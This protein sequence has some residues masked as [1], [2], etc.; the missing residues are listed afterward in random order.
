MKVAQLA[1]KETFFE[2]VREVDVLCMYLVSVLISNIRTGL[3]CWADCGRNMGP[4]LK[5]ASNIMYS[6]LGSLVPYYLDWKF[7]LSDV[8]CLHFGD[9][10][11]VES[12]SDTHVRSC[13][14]ACTLY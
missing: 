12:L 2:V 6:F 5:T 4:L 1:L 7:P 8:G 10:T 11:L 9:E 3:F 14:H 13:T